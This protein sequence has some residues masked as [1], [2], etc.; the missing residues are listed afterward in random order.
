MNEL[1]RKTVNQIL[2]PGTYQ[3]FKG[4][5]YKVQGIAVHS[6]TEELMV[7]YSNKDGL[8]VRPL[9]MF[10]EVVVDNR[11]NLIPRFSRIGD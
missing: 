2:I 8:W 10:L 3:H 6:E 11:G 9:S 4:G 1:H 7:V 5:I